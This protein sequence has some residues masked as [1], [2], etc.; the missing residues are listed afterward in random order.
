MSH[1]ST[2]LYGVDTMVFIYHFEGNP[3]FGTQAGRLLLSAE[4]GRCHLVASIL[5]LMEILV[6][7]KRHGD[8]ALST[9]YRELFLVFPNLSLQPIDTEIAEIAA[10]LRAR[11]RLRTPDALHLATAIHHGADGF[12][13]EDARLS[14]VEEIPILRLAEV[15]E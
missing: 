9:F 4:E 2:P 12:V 6:V 1:Q 5:T 10:E 3:Q 14:I 15:G 7:P 8:L 11:H 13:T